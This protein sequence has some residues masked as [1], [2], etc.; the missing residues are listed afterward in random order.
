M[1]QLALPLGS[2]HCIDTFKVIGWAG[3]CELRRIHGM[4]PLPGRPAD[5]G[6]GMP[7]EGEDTGVGHGGI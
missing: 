1:G 2:M 5:R 7:R 3:Y 4:G 6:N